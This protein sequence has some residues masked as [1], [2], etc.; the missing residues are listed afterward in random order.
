M[1]LY[2]CPQFHPQRTRALESHYPTPSG[3]FNPDAHQITF[4]SMINGWQRLKNIYKLSGIEFEESKD[5]H[6]AT[7]KS[8]IHDIL[9]PK[10]LASIVNMEPE[11]EE[12]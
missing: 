1:R 6:T 11:T 8:K 7:I 12:L 10:K 2:E 3:R 4:C 5:I 9:K